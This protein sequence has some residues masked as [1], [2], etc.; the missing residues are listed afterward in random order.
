MSMQR[1]ATDCQDAALSPR[2]IALVEQADAKRAAEARVL[3]A[4]RRDLLEGWGEQRPY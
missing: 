4:F 2:A 1:N 3:D